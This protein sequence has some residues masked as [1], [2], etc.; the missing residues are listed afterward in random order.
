[1]KAVAGRQ[2]S[3][4][5]AFWTGELDTIQIARALEREHYIIVAQG[6]GE[7]RGRI[8]RIS[9]IG[10][11]AAMLRGLATALSGV[12]ASMGRT[13]DMD[14]IQPD[15]DRLLEDCVIWE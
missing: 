10:K 13:L 3:G 2:A 4:V 7:L 12:L 8:L 6:Q 5:V 1:M 9:P 14:A 11:S 15:F